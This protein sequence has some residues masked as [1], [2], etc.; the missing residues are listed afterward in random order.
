MKGERMFQTGEVPCAEAGVMGWTVPK[1]RHWSPNPAYL[2]MWPYKKIIADIVSYICKIRSYWSMCVFA[3]EGGATP[4]WLVS[5]KS[6]GNADIDMHTR[7]TPCKDEGQIRV[8]LLQVTGCQR[9]SANYQKLGKRHGTNLP[10]STQK[11]INLPTSWSQTSSLHNCEAINFC[12]LSHL[13]CGTL[14]GQP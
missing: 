2:I 10:H 14:L 11:K 4:T 3:G 6:G 12:C 1:F 8:K 9:F 7:R 5:S 13:L